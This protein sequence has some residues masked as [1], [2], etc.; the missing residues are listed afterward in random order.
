MPIAVNPMNQPNKND[1][2]WLALPICV[3]VIG[4]L[5]LRQCSPSKEPLNTVYY[6]DSIFKTDTVYTN[7]IVTKTLSKVVR[8]SV[9]IPP[10]NSDSNLCNY[11]RSYTDTVIDS[12][13]VIYTHKKVQGL[14]LSDELEMQ[15]TCP[16]TITNTITI[17]DS[18]VVK[19]PEKYPL[20]KKLRTF[21]GGAITG[22]A[23][24]LGLFLYIENK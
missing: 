2:M 15:I 8:D 18:V 24:A 10:I 3:L 6:H 13:V 20:R 11:V 21:V 9:F 14:L 4:L 5:L 12:C 16:K 17:K 23:T 19:V 1:W 22:F 7:R